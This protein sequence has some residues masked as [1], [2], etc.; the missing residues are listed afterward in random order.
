VALADGVGLPAHLL[1]LP[2]ERA[3]TL[4]GAVV[5]AL[6][7]GAGRMIDD[8]RARVMLTACFRAGEEDC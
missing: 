1:L 3:K 2:F 4:C 5:W 7:M 6:E 8:L